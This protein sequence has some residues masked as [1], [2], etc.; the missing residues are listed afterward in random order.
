M[1]MNKNN[2]FYLDKEFFIVFNKFEDFGYI[3]CMSRNN[4]FTQV[5]AICW[6]SATTPSFLIRMK[7]DQL[8][9]KIIKACL[10]NL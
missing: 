7:G 10:Q 9:F 8:S 4:W 5:V 1:N 2:G 3:I 6:Q